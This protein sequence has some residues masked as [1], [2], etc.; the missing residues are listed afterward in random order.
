[1]ASRSPSRPPPNNIA[2]AYRPTTR[3][4]PDQQTTAKESADALAAALEDLHWSTRQPK[5]VLLAAVVDVALG[6]V[7]EV[8]RRFDAQ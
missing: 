7:D 6:H 1:D 5:H 2:P 4:A 8:R 3:S